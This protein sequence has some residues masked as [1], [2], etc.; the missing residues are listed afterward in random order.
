MIIDN[1]ENYTRLGENIEWQRFVNV[2]VSYVIFL[3]II[4]RGI[5]SRIPDIPIAV[6]RKLARKLEN[7]IRGIDLLLNTNIGFEDPSVSSQIVSSYEKARP[8]YIEFKKACGYDLSSFIEVMQNFGDQI[9][10]FGKVVPGPK[11]KPKPSNIFILPDVLRR[12]IKAYMQ[13]K[14]QK[15]FVIDA[16][17]NP[18]EIEYFKRRYSEFY[19]VCINRPYKDRQEALSELNPKSSEKLQERESGKLIKKK[20]KTNIHEWVTS[21][22]LPECLQRSDYFIHN[23]FDP[24]KSYPALRYNLIRLM[25]L[26]QNPGC[27]PPTNNERC[28]QIAMTARQNSG[29]ISRHVGA[30]VV[31]RGGYVLGVAENDPPHGQIPCSLRTADEL[32]RTLDEEVF[33][34]FERSAKFVNHITKRSIH[35]SPFCFKDE[36]EMIDN[37]KQ[38]EYTRA[39]HAEENALLQAMTHGP[40]SLHE[41]TLYTTDSPCNLCAKKAYQLGVTQIIFVEEYPGISDSQTL[42]AGKRKI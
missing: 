34:E 39:L 21:Q 38:N 36:L 18:F 25:C 14:K 7:G 3:F 11:L 40:D 15:Y 17:R 26:W 5:H 37:K 30:I 35:N 20:T 6:A 33:S 28:M 2:E 22:N 10:T 29:C 4:S 42:K 12:V 24:S 19:L 32:L 27:I 9:R 1:I 31:N 16:F 8:L 41:S 13:N 23:E